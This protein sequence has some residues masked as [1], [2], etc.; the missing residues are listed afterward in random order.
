MPGRGGHRRVVRTSMVDAA[1][2]GSPQ[3]PAP[4]RGPEPE[5]AD[6]TEAPR[7]TVGR[8][9]SA[10]PVVPARA[11]EDS[12]AAWGDGPDSNDQRLREDVPPHW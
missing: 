8:A 10:L 9:D 12:D 4:A 11:A 3:L 7:P 1:R 5:A 2:D 6:P